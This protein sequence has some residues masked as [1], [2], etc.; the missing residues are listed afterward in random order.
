[1]RPAA[2]LLLC[3][4]GLAAAELYHARVRTPRS[5]Q[6]ESD[7]IQSS[8]QLLLINATSAAAV[9]EMLTRA[10]D[11]T[12]AQV[13]VDVVRPVRVY[14]NPG[15]WGQ[16]RVDQRTV[17]LNDD[18]A[19][20]YTG[21]S[22]TA[23]VVDTGIETTH[24]DFQSRAQLA[25]NAY[26]P[27][28]DCHGHG[29]HVAS[30]LGG[31]QYGIAK[32]VQ[33]RSVKVLDCFGYGTTYTVAQGLQW[34]LDHLTGRDVINLSLGYGARDVVIES[35]LADLAEAGVVAV[36]AAGNA[37]ANACNHFPSAHES[38]I[39]VGATTAS[40]VRA[41]YSNFGSCVDLMAPGSGIRAARLGGGS[42]TMSGTSMATP[43]VAGAAALL[44][45][46]QNNTGASVRAA[47]TSVATVN[48]L[49]G[50]EGSPNR[51]VWVHGNSTQQPPIS[52][53]AAAA[54][55]PNHWISTAAVAA[56]IVLSSIT[57]N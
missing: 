21:A 1:M 30:T 36:A 42:T 53:S 43:H 46:L 29:T 15:S 40:D 51:L 3:L 50:L 39:S 27:A 49:S 10:R 54:A 26:T 32:G 56:I 28:S 24:A 11:V 8:G 2:L 45:S 7:G 48:A 14:A 19:P 25:F 38:V 17:A 52:G 4:I 9:R 34:I 44:L 18:Y 13:F 47:L 33:L 41:S 16:D 31:V 37:D 20:L 5:S 35:L 55:K 6:V 23:W 22:V 12:D 57:V